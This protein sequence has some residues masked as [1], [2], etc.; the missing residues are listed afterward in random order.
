MHIFEMQDFSLALRLFLKYEVSL[1]LYSFFKKKYDSYV[2]LIGRKE[3]LHNG[4]YTGN[5]YGIKKERGSVENFPL[6][7]YLSFFIFF[8]PFILRIAVSPSKLERTDCR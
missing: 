1:F 6:P 7:F 2:L 5:R 3:A 4:K 8:Y